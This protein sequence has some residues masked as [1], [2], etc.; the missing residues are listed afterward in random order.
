[1]IA[2]KIKLNLLWENLNLYFFHVYNKI[3]QNFYYKESSHFLNFYKN[4]NVFLISLLSILLILYGSL[5]GKK[6]SLRF[7]P[8]HLEEV[9]IYDQ[10]KYLG[11]ARIID[12]TQQKHK[13]VEKVE[14]DPLV[15]SEASKLNFENI[16]S[17]YQEY[18]EKQLNE[19]ITIIDNQVKTE[20]DKQKKILFLKFPKKKLRLSKER[21]LLILFLLL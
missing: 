8:F 11:L 16:K 18:L 12:L 4:L 6:I 10:D 7:D 20:N 2:S 1:L 14:K 17:N 13:D 15:I 21:N 3:Y 9:H 5:V 19:P